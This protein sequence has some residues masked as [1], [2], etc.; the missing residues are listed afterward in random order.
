MLEAGAQ[1]A[2]D[3]GQRF[4]EGD[5]AGGGYGS[6]A[7]GPDVGDPQVAGAHLR[8]GHGAGIDGMRQIFAEEVN[9]RH[10][11][12]PGED[13]A[14]EHGARGARADDVAHAEILGRGVGLD[15]CAFEHVLRA[16]VGLILGRA[17]PCAEEVLVLEE[18]V[19]GAQAEAEEDAA[20]ERTALGA[21]HEHVG[22]GRALRELQG[23]VLFHNERAAQ[24]HHEEHAEIAADERQHEDAGVFEIEAEKDER[25]QSE[26]DAGGD[27]LA[28]VAR[29]LDD[30]AFEDGDLALVAQEAD[31]DDRD[32]NGGGHGEPGA[33]AHIDG[34]GAKDDAEK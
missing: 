21:G 34:D 12:E 20:G 32:G 13:A 22:A 23:A 5:E 30:D 31:G 3:G 33:Q 29:G 4:E 27:G 28:G 10:E 24:R 8:D 15:G 25:G 14:G 9:E 16:E 1:R 2:D 18:G 7:H 26:D 19:E 11:D 6:G 17:G